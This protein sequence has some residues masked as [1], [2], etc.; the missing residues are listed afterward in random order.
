MTYRD[1]LYSTDDGVATIAINRPQRLNAITGHSIAEIE[2]ALSVA[3]RDRDVGVIVLTGVGNR[4]FSVGGDLAWEAEGGLENTRYDLGRKLVEHAKPIIARVDGYAIGAGNHMAYFCDFTIA[5]DVST[6]G[7]NGTRVAAIPAGYTATHLAAIIG[8]KRAREMEFF[9]RKHTAQQALEWGLINAVVP[10][11][12][13]DA[14]VRAWCDELLMMSPT[15]MAALKASFRVAMEP[16][17]NLTLNEV[18]A[19][20][21]PDFFR[22][23]E[24]QEGAASFFEKRR[25]DYSRWR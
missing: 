9:C 20:V 10:R 3:G 18:I 13:L 24:Q 2:D 5:S 19:K 4:A 8:H 1:I 7:Q 12:Q 17:F 22:S 14:T 25:P 16:Y 15:A 23:G 11:E 6:F 21:K